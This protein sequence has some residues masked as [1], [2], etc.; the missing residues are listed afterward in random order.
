M[1]IQTIEEWQSRKSL[2]FYSKSQ[3]SMSQSSLNNLYN[4]VTVQTEGPSGLRNDVIE[5]FFGLIGLK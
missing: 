1:V 3:S 4:K 2:F 5:S